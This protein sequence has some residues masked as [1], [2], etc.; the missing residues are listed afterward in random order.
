MSRA[1]RLGFFVTTQ[2]WFRLDGD[3]AP[4]LWEWRSMGAPDPRSLVSVRRPR[5]SA[6]QRHIP[7]SAFSYTVGGHLELESGLEHDLV[8]VLDRRRDIV[9]LVAQPCRWIFTDTGKRHVPDL[10]SVSTSGEVTLWDVRPESRRNETFETQ[11]A[12]A[13]AACAHV[14]CSYE[15]FTG[16]SM[17]ERLN[18]LWL[19]GYRRRTPWVDTSRPLIDAAVSAERATIGELCALDDGSGELT[20]AMWHL[21]WTGDLLVPLDEKLSADT[22][23]RGAGDAGR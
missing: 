1:R 5:S 23:V 14:G 21:I 3:E 8:R 11:S 7:V 20:S 17:V 18:L 12:A 9:W 10:L 19:H 6:R 16:V 4:V 13:A 15:V 2:W 22:P